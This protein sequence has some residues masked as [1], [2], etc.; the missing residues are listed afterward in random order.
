MKLDN[1]SKYLIKNI[2]NILKN[3]NNIY[4]VL[5]NLDNTNYSN[6][7]LNLLSNYYS[8]LIYSKNKISKY[9]INLN[10]NRLSLNILL[11]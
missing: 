1:S 4:S 5:K 10:S 7:L 6:K 8:N 2:N 9:F 11:I 3:N